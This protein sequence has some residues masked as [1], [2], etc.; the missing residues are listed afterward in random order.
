MYT[1]AEIRRTVK[2]LNG[3][4]VFAAS[5]DPDRPWQWSGPYSQPAR[6]AVMIRRGEAVVHACSLVWDA[7]AQAW[8]R[9]PDDEAAAQ[10]L[11]IVMADRLSAGESL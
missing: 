4:F 8:R 7:T 9:A 3:T 2:R 11:Q 5:T 6:G 10:L 1:T